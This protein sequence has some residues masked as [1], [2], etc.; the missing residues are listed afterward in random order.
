MIIIGILLIKTIN[1]LIICLKGSLIAPITPNVIP[2]IA[3]AITAI[4]SSSTLC[5]INKYVLPFFNKS[6]KFLKISI[7]FGNIV[8]SFF[9]S[10]KI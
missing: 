9:I 7:T 5:K 4:T 6:K 10:D 1:G 8:L 2:T 3:E